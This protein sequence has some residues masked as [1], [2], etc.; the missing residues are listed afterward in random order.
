MPKQIQGFISEY[1]LKG[2]FEAHGGE[3]NPPFQSASEYQAAAIA[4]LQ[5]PVAG[6]IKQGLRVRDGATI[7][8]DSATD[9]FAICNASGEVTTYFKANPAVH[10]QGDNDSY[11]RRRV[12]Q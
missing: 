1:D 8:F 4:F 2:H 3:F 9:E 6:T 12:S 11:F 7:R 5:K 10:K